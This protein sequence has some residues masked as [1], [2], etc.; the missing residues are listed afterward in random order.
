MALTKTI[1]LSADWR[2]KLCNGKT[3]LTKPL[4]SGIVGNIVFK[5]PDGLYEICNKCGVMSIG[6]GLNRRVKDREMK[7]SH[8]P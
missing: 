4:K 3:A 5:S 8:I 7:V 2:C 6:G 1:Y